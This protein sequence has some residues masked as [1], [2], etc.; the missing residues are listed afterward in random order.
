MFVSGVYSNFKF[1][2]PKV[3]IPKE[4]EDKYIPYLERLPGNMITRVIDFL[5]YSIQ[6]I[7]LQINPQ[8]YTPNL[9]KS[10]GWINPHLTRDTSGVPKGIKEP[11]VRYDDSAPYDLQNNFVKEMTI[12]F[13]LDSSYLIYFLLFDIWTYY[14]SKFEEKY[15][16]QSPGFEIIDGYGQLLYS[17]NLEKMLMTSLSNLEFNYADTSVDMKTIEAN[18]VCQSISIEYLKK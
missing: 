14:N 10:V 11:G 18:F 5:N 17:I 4:I 8:N 12:T 7:N 2:F 15:L 9:Q 1:E 3:L 16:P 13:Q 6:S